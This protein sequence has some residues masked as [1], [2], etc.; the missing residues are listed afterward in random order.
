MQ[1]LSATGDPKRWTHTVVADLL[2]SGN[3]TITVSGTCVVGGYAYNSSDGIIDGDETSVDSITFEI[4]KIPTINAPDINKT[5]G[6]S[7]FSVSPTSNST[8]NITFAL[9]TPGIVSITGTN[10]FSI[11]KAGSTVVSVTQASDGNFNSTTVTFTLTVNKASPVI[12]VSDINKTYGDSDFTLTVSSTSPATTTFVSPF[13]VISISGNTASILSSGERIVTV[14]QVENENYLSATATFKVIVDR[15]D[16]DITVGDFNKVYGDFDFFVSPSSL[17]SSPYSFTPQTS[18]VVSF[19]GNKVSIIG[20]GSS[21]VLVTQNQDSKYNSSTTTFTINVGKSPAGTGGAL[22][23]KIN[24]VGGHYVNPVIEIPS[25]SYDDV[26]VEGISRLGTGLTKAT[27]S[28]LLVDLEVGAA[29]TSVGIGSTFFEISNFQVSRHGHSF[30]IGD[31]VRPIGLVHDKRLQKPI[32]E[33]ELEV[34]SIFNDYFAAWQFG[35]I[36]FIDSIRG[37]QDGTRTRFPLFFNGQLL[38]FMTDPGDTVS[39]QI[40]LDAVLIIFINGVLQTPKVAYQFNGGTTFK[41]TEPPDASDNVDVFFY[42]G[43]RNVDVEIVDI[44]ETLKVGDDVRVYKSPLFKD[45]FTQDDERVIK[46]IQGSDIIETNVYTG[47]GINENDPKPLRWTKQKEDLS[48]KGELIS[49]SR[50]SIEPQIYP[51]ARVIGDVETNTGIG[52]NGGI[53]VDDAESFYYE[54]SSNP[55]LEG[56]DRYNVTINSVDTLII[57]GAPKSTA[58]INAVVSAAGTIQS[59]TIVDGGSGYT[60]TPTISIGAPI[61]VGVGTETRDQFAVAGVSTFATATVTIT[62][63]SIDSYDITNEGLGYSQSN[64]PQITVDNPL[65]HRKL[66]S[67]FQKFINSVNMKTKILECKTSTD[68]FNLINDWEH[69]YLSKESI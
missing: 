67:R 45:S 41:F 28:N 52:V 65:L 39:E 50:S 62:D 56:G 29:K 51:T 46:S 18:G 34:N 7:N 9:V 26:P 68:I 30:K 17:N 58:S 15:A 16:T 22:D 12:T 36:D 43:D 57:E 54:D 23:L 10:T 48:I 5:F 6:D 20:A 3:Y 2:S 63:G 66:I 25:P 32:Q 37:Y 35:E 47:V 8:G 61:G 55:A 21:V 13:G 19:T 60:A 53:F 44:Q 49:K 24:E 42:I 64:P 14:S 59:L 1:N 4:D 27:G 38:S 33:F 31:K 11:V 69:I 40:D